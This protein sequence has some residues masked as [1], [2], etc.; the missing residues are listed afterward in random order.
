MTDYRQGDGY[1]FS[2]W[3]LDHWRLLV[4]VTRATLE[5]LAGGEL[6]DQLSTLAAFTG[7]L[8]ERALL[9][10]ANTGAARV[11]FEPPDVA[12]LTGTEMRG[13]SLLH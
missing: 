3:L 10:H 8:R 4:H 12:G 1:E 2:I 9:V 13:P 6:I 5:F 7:L 11:V